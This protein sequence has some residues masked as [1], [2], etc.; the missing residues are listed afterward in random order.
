MVGATSLSVVDGIF[1]V[2]LR[3]DVFEAVD[4]ARVSSVEARVLLDLLDLLVSVA[5]VSLI[6]GTSSSSPSTDGSCELG[7]STMPAL[8]RLILF[9]AV[10]IFRAR[11]ASFSLKRSTS[12]DFL[13]FAGYE[14]SWVTN[15]PLRRDTVKLAGSKPGERY[16]SSSSDVVAM[17]AGIC[18][19]ARTDKSEALNVL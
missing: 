12:W 11:G 13:A 19:A 14:M 7:T 9:R 5:G 3:P 17:T 1:V 2:L 6:G 10:R 16:S 8:V 15:I 18:E 4:S